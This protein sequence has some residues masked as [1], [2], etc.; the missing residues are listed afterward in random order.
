M[1]MS[2]ESSFASLH[3]TLD[4]FS[5]KRISAAEL[6]RAWRDQQELLAALPPRYREVM[7]DLLGRVEAGSLFTEE[8][9]S[10]SQ[11]DLSTS[12]SSWLDMARQQLERP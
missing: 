12:L 11:E 1:A 7:E 6:C 2:Y 9:C 10:F 5:E 3:T 4:S 8:S